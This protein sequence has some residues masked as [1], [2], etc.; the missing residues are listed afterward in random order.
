MY[1][2]GIQI[3]QVEEDGAVNG[4]KTIKPV[5]PGFKTSP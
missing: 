1:E 2:L 3:T 4:R 5:K